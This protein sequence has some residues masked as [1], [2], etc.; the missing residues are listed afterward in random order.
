VEGT[1]HGHWATL[2]SAQAPL[3]PL[4]LRE[5]RNAR[6]Q[7]VS[8]QQATETIEEGLCVQ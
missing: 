7:A 4:N 3:H 1:H 8:K 2:S 6:K 5:E